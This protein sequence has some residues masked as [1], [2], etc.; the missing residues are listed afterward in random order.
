M[1]PELALVKIYRRNRNVIVA[2]LPRN[3]IIIIK[4]ILRL[5]DRIIKS[6]LAHTTRSTLIASRLAPFEKRRTT[7]NELYLFMVNSIQTS[8]QAAYSQSID[9]SCAL[10]GFA[11]LLKITNGSLIRNVFCIQMACTQ[12]VSIVTHSGYDLL[13]V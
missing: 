9:F 1:W 11:F 2:A 8:F 13:F 6:A 7:T 4:N 5:F 12:R 3:Q 10:C